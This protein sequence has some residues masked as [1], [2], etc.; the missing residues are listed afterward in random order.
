MGH[1]PI[2]L[3][4]HRS[5]FILPVI[6]SVA[7]THE[8]LQFG[9]VKWF[10]VFRSSEDKKA[11]ILQRKYD[12]YLFPFNVAIAGCFVSP[13]EAHAAI[14]ITGCW[15]GYEGAPHPRKIEALAGFKIGVGE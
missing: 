7:G 3:G 11:P 15:R 4:R 10:Q 5:F 1:F 6:E 14:V 13:D 2:V 12:G 9:G 8:D